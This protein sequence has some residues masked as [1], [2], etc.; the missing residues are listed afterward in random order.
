MRRS[1][2]IIWV[3]VLTCGLS[4]GV[5]AADPVLSDEPTALIRA[6]L[7]LDKSRI[8][9]GQPV[10]AQFLLTN[11]TDDTVVLQVPDADVYEGSSREMGLPLAHVFSGRSF[12]AVKIEDTKRSI[13]DTKGRVPPRAPVPVVRLAPRASVGS[14]LNLVEYC[15]IL[16]RAGEYKLTWWPYQG[17]VESKP[18][19]L[20]VRS[21]RQA[22]I[23]TDFGKMT[24]RFYDEQAPNH[25]DNFIELAENQFYD[26]LT[27][28]RLVPGG[29]LQGG[30]P[31]GDGR[32]LRKDGK[33]LKA[34]FSSIPFE[35]GT[36]GMARSRFDPD[37]AS[38]QFFICLGRQPSFDG[39]QTAFGYLVGK[40]SFETMEKIAEIP[41]DPKD[42]PSRPVYIRTISLEN[43]SARE[44]GKSPSGPG[45][46][47]SRPAVVGN[48]SSGLI[49]LR[50]V[51]KPKATTE[52]AGTLK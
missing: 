31:R 15:R 17:L 2:L 28:H 24:M 51:R 40:E 29:V 16:R 3:S 18:V 1:C 23:L 27:F 10:W 48:E 13:L 47:T 5:R 45:K 26:N 25:A 12:S 14:R 52:P 44:R 43:V 38:C 49:G 21:E 37:S 50:A 35:R 22:T 7:R 6:E 8:R 41:A 36:V 30:D 11:M 32:G 46:A 33:R 20:L 42:S 9:V 4:V 39:N 19:T 34:E